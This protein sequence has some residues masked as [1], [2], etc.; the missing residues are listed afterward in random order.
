MHLPEGVINFEILLLNSLGEGEMISP[1]AIDNSKILHT[2]LKSNRKKI[3]GKKLSIL[4]ELRF[5]M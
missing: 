1:K 2:N 4:N 5:G 3:L